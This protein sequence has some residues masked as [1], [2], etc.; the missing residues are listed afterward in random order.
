MKKIILALLFSV[1][2]LTAVAEKAIPTITVNGAGSVMAAPDTAIISFGVENTGKELAPL[3]KAN[4]GAVKR[5]ID[6]L[7]KSGIDRKD[8]YTSNYNISHNYDYRQKN[9]DREKVYT[10]RNQF[11]LTLTDIERVGEIITLLEKNGVNTI[12]GVNYITSKVKELKL[13][14]L[15]KAYMDAKEK[16]EHLASLEGKKVELLSINT[17]G[18]IPRPEVYMAAD[19]ARKNTTPIYNPLEISVDANITAVF[20]I[21]K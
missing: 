21:V 2:C 14:A 13:E 4:D 6:A 16:S 10:V 5:S 17:G 1:V 19:M 8:I 18:Y 9:K 11:R 12:Q 20:K 7:I 3:K 15:E